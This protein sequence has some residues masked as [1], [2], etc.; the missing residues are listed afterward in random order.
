M[1]LYLVNAAVDITLELYVSPQAE[2]AMSI[3]WERITDRNVR[4]TFV[5][6]LE[7][8]FERALAESL[9]WDIKPPT[10]SQ[11]AY[12]KFIAKQQNIPLPPEAERF[13]FHAAMFLETYASKSKD[14]SIMPTD[15]NTEGIA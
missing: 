11:L 5:R 10:P 14:R 15:G 7:A 12:A 2:E 9:D 6:K 4:D 3:Q 13:R 8:H 1:T